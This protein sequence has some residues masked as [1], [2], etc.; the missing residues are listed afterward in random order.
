MRKLF[1][2]FLMVIFMASVSM[3]ANPKGWV[4][5]KRGKGI[6]VPASGVFFTENAD[7]PTHG[8]LA[9]G[10]VYFDTDDNL[11]VRAGGAWVDLTVQAGGS[12][13]LDGAF[14]NGKIINGANSDANAVQIGD[15]TDA[16]LLH[17]EGAGDVRI[18]TNGT[19]DLT[20][21]PD[22]GDTDITGTL[23]VSGAVTTAALT[24]GGTF[25]VSSGGVTVTSGG[26][27]VDAGGIA[28]AG[29]LTVEDTGLTVSAGGINVT[30]GVTADAAT[31]TGNIT[32]STGDLVASAG[33]LDISGGASNEDLADFTR[34]NTASGGDG[35]DLNMG[36]AVIAGDAIDVSWA[37]AGTVTEPN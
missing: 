26:I 2:S 36:S 32:T 22:G 20:I 21:I 18:T 3:A 12:L 19:S 28:V 10:V 4:D 31:I 35:I 7:A 16:I 24:A 37:G 6:K 15:G 11:Y 33:E 14:D 29:G 8:D 25:T 34:S 30:G 1:V 13:T 17:T 5:I 23:D 9:D 27:D